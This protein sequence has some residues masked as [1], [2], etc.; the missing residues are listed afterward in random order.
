MIK[1]ITITLL[2]L[3]FI[4]SNEGTSLFAQSSESNTYEFLSVPVSAHS[5][6]LGGRNVSITEDDV[7]LIFS[8][9]AL[10]TNVSHN[11]V[12][13]DYTSYIG[14]TMKLSAAFARQTGERGTWA[15]AAQYLSYGT[16][17]ETDALG[18]KINDFTPAD[19]ALQGTF[20]YLLTDYWSG[21]VTGKM[22]ISN[23]GEYKAFAMGV[24]L[25]LNYFNPETDLSLSFVGK[26]F[27]GQID[28]LYETKEALPFDFSIGLSKGLGHAPIR[29]NFTF[30]DLTHWKNIN[31]IQHLIIG[32]DVFIGKSVWAGVGYNFRQA[33]EMKTADNSSHMAGFGIGGGINVNKFKIA[34]AW[35]K[36]H[37]SSSSLIVNASFAF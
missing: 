13:L 8:N 1:K 6:A 24:D 32:A 19:I 25:G 20:A 27:G 34:L 29:L 17:D 12:N 2:F 4:S 7:T 36:Y 11:T 9:P 35:S 21:A 28:P 5:A 14:S 15:V 3:L 18:N 16:M 30:D 37:I 33:H 31:F 23:Y 10:L 22:I 26:N